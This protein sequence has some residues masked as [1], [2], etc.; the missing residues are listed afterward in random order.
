M[1]NKL[2]LSLII[3]TSLLMGCNSSKDDIYLSCNGFSET[4]NVYGNNIEQKRES[5]VIPV[6]I[7]RMDGLLEG[8]LNPPVYQ[9]RIGYTVFEDSHLFVDKTQYV[10][11]H[12][13]LTDSNGNQTETRFNINRNTNHFIYY[14][15][16]FSPKR[17]EH[18]KTQKTID[19]E[20]KCEKVK[21]KI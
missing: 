7:R 3:V 19:F 16:F 11:T 15:F 13:R 12:K 8:L 9:I 5:L 6:Q 20:G 21:E 14:D 4:I 2:Y 18:D 10:G 17:K 1:K